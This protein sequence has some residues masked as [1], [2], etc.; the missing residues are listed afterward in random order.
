M[1][2]DAINVQAVIDELMNRI[3]QLELEVA[4]LKATKIRDILAPDDNKQ[5]G[6]PKPPGGYI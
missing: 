3:A 6:T 4:I 2:D 1:A 5:E